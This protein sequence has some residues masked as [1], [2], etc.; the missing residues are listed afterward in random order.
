[1]PRFSS[2]HY[3]AAEPSFS[4]V[5]TYLGFRGIFLDL[6]KLMVSSHATYVLRD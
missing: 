3:V 6:I 4:R 2:H 1:M 5:L